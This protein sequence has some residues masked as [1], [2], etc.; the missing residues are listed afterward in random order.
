MSKLIRIGP[1]VP[2][3]ISAAGGY[4]VKTGSGILHAIVVGE[5][6]AAAITA[7]DFG[8][9]SLIGTRVVLKASVV[10][11]TYTFNIGFVRGLFIQPDG[12]SKI[13]ILYQ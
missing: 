5:T 11:G 1:F 9:G 13:T 8:S 4:Q 12:D 2:Y 7:L 6:A 10:E 3:Y